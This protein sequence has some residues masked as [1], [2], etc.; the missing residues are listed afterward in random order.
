[1]TNGEWPPWVSQDLKFDGLASHIVTEAFATEGIKV[2]YEFLPWKRAYLEA[3]T[4]RYAESIIWSKKA[5]READFFYSDEIFT[6]E[7]VFF[8]LK[9]YPFNWNTLDDLVGYKIG[10]SFATTYGKNFDDAVKSG[11]L[12]LQLTVKDEFNFKKLLLKRI[13]IF[14]SNRGVGYAIMN[15]TL[16]PEEVKLITH[17]P[18]PITTRSYHLIMPKKAEK[19]SQELLRLF[20]RGLKRLNEQGTVQQFI[21][22]SEKGKYL[23]K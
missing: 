20:N 2:E 4:G 5:E 1:L 15:K 9:S 8:H 17:H 7:K 23:K 3:Q 6:D 18:K 22:E 13:Q 11:K 19:K 16:K 12:T 10:G 14:P 21:V